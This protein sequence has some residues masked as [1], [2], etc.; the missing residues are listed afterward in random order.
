MKAMILAAGE[1]TRLRPYTLRLPKP[2][3]PFLG[4]PLVDYCIRILDEIQCREFVVNHHHMSD[5]IIR[6]FQ[7]PLLAGRNVEFSDERSS[8][9]G[10]GGGVHKAKPF[11]EKEKNFAVM[12]GDEI[13]LS[14]R[15]GQIR[16]AWDEHVSS[17]RLATILVTAHPE[18]GK[19]FGGVW[20]DQQTRVQAFSKTPISGLKGWHYIGLLFLSNRVFN[21]FK[22]EIVEENLLYETLSLGMSK[23]EEIRVFPMEAEWFESGN[24]QDFRM[25]VEVCLS[26]INSENPKEWAKELKRF[27]TTR[28]LVAPLIEQDDPLLMTKFEQT[29]KKLGLL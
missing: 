15:T 8:L 16:S 12:N 6:L 23:G 1:G 21:Y 18:V 7:R 17:G 25:A 14:H 10:S 24:P 2:A 19:K 29:M 22:P 9:L 20:C 27:L 11:L 13:I 5:E 4:V 3:I 28:S 26:E